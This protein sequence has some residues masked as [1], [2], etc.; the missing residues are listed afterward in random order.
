MNKN[1]I[2]QPVSF[3]SIRSLEKWSEESEGH[4]NEKKIVNGFRSLF[5]NNPD[6]VKIWDI[7]GLFEGMDFIELYTD[8]PSGIGQIWT[9][10]L[11]TPS[12]AK[13]FASEAVP[14]NEIDGPFPSDPIIVDL[15]SGYLSEYEILDFMKRWNRRWF[16]D[17]QTEWVWDAGEYIPA[18]EALDHLI[19]DQNEPEQNDG[20]HEI[21]IKM[22]PD[23]EE[24]EEFISWIGKRD[25]CWALIKDEESVIIRCEDKIVAYAIQSEWGLKFEEQ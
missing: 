5:K 14:E 13:E 10:T 25:H 8:L 9:H 22:T 17:F 7:D 24:R 21:T 16:P 11:V 19:E 6:S 20:L 1:S 2:L 15:G 3:L 4:F 18:N 12:G 23:P